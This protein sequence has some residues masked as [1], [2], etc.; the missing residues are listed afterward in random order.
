LGW[1][2][3]ERSV[4]P[5]RTRLVQSS[6]HVAV[7]PRY[8]ALLF[9]RS[10][11]ARTRLIRD[12]CDLSLQNKLV[13][14]VKRR[15]IQQENGDTDA[16]ICVETIA[17]LQHQP[18]QFILRLLNTNID[19]K[20]KI[21]YALTEIRGVGRRY[22]NVVC[23]KADVDLGKRSACVQPRQKSGKKSEAHYAYVCLQCRRAQPR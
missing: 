2:R 21:M 17:V 4:P 18:F 11:R 10:S 19:G 15:Y 7:C 8:A 5:T 3:L 9:R 13:G 14:T 22:A 16:V 6:H 23:K 20:R 12:M 1:G